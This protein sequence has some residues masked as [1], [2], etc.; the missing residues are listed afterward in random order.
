MRQE[1]NS[2]GDTPMKLTAAT[3]ALTVAL[4]A[5]ALAADKGGD[6]PAVRLPPEIASYDWSGV[7]AGLHAGFV[8]DG[9]EEKIAGVHIGYRRQ[10]GSFVYG[11][12]AG[13]TMGDLKDPKLE[14]T[15][16]DITGSLGIAIDRLLVY[17]KGGYVLNENVDGWTYGAGAAF[18]ITQR[19]TLGAEF[20]RT[21]VGLG[22]VDTAMARVGYRF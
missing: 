17:G 4:G 11:I 10:S 7:Y 22:N 21:D 13:A 19:I 14:N 2:I 1:P 12:E 16:F 6:I 15:L 20:M 8:M 5:S 18:A 3:I 9:T